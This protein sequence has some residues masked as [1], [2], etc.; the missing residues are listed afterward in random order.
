[1]YLTPLAID[2]RAAG[3]KFRLR[4][5]RAETLLGLPPSTAAG[6]NRSFVLTIGNW[7]DCAA[8]RRYPV[9]NLLTPADDVIHLEV[10]QI[11]RMFEQRLEDESATN[12]S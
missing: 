4:G 11:W 10:G 6:S 3:G 1:V 7:D 2:C 9:S 8:G 12:L 5:F